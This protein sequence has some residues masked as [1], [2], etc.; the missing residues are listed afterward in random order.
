MDGS[1]GDEVLREAHEQDGEQRIK[2]GRSD[3]GS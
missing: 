1:G 2:S 3:V